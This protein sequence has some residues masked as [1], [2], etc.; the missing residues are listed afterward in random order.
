MDQG[1]KRRRSGIRDHASGFA[2]VDE[3]ARIPRLL[4]E[5]GAPDRK[6]SRMER[7][8]RTER[9]RGE[10]V[11]QRGQALPRIGAARTRS[12]QDSPR[13]D[14]PRSAARRTVSAAGGRVG[15]LNVFHTLR[16]RLRADY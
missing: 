14:Q 4:G 7:R 10:I 15:A 1:S 2:R 5:A 6:D 16:R 12:D 13:T 8:A 11:I 3:R 9:L